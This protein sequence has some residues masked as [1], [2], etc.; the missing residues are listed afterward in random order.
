[1]AG[2]EIDPALASALDTL[3]LA[4]IPPQNGAPVIWVETGSE[5]RGPSPASQRVIDAWVEKG[6]SVETR[7]CRGDPFWTIQETTVA[8]A[9]IEATLE[10]LHTP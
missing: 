2:Y 8:P 10:A 5:D 1:M 6:V 4:D 9:I 7:L 3:R